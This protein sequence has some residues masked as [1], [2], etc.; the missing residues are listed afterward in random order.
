[1][2]EIFIG[3]PVHWLFWIAV[4]PVL[5]F[6]GLER[7]HVR[8]FNLFLLLLGILGLGAVFFVRWTTRSG[9]SVTRESIE[10]GTFQQSIIDE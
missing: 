5:Y 7:L 1:M 8:N 2:R 6:A 9:E 10:A 3:K 4:I